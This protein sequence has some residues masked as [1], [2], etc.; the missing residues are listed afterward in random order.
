MQA[1]SAKPP[2]L[3]PLVVTLFGLIV[4]FQLG[5]ALLGRS[6]IRASHLGTALEYARADHF[7]VDPA[8]G[9]TRW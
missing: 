9:F 7:A 5:N 2:A 1:D 8:V 4:A 3:A 6:S